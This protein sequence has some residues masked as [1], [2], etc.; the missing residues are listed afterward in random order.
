MKSIIKL[1]TLT[2]FFSLLTT[3]AAFSYNAN[4][5]QQVDTFNNTALSDMQEITL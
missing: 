3:A 1:I 2:V 4:L 5:I